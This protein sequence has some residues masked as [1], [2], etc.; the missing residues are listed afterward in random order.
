MIMM[1]DISGMNAD[2]VELGDKLSKLGEEM[3]ADIKKNTIDWQLAYT[4][5]EEEPVYL[6]GIIYQ[7]NT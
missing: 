1:V 4:D 3:L 2:F 6:P 5:V 7:T